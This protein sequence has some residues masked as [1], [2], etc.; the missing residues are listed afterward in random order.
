MTWTGADTTKEEAEAMVE[1]MNA[2]NGAGRMSQKMW[3][4]SYHCL[5]RVANSAVKDSL[6]HMLPELG[7]FKYEAG[8]KELGDPKWLVGFVFDGK[9]D[10][11]DYV[12]NVHHECVDES[13]FQVLE[14]HGAWHKEF[15]E[16][17]ERT[18]KMVEDRERL[19]SAAKRGYQRF[20]EEYSKIHPKAKNTEVLDSF[21]RHKK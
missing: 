3:N 4:M 2:A 8:D 15:V 5:E 13:L 7:E 19:E 14:N 9:P 12:A 20:A 18:T 21:K 6:K 17:K 11:D 1:M 10:A 16:G